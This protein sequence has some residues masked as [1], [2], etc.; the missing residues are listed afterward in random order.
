MAIGESDPHVATLITPPPEPGEAATLPTLDGKPGFGGTVPSAGTVVRYFGDYE[1]LQEIARGGMGVVFKARQVKLNRVVALKMILSGDLAGEEEVQRFK[2]EA[3]AAANLD[4]P[5]IVPIY[6]IGEHNGQH[7]FSMAFV[8]GQSLA[9]KVKDGPLTPRE[10]AQIVKRVTDSVAYAHMKGVIHRD[11]KPANVLL[12]GDGQ[13]K[14]TD[15][16]LAKQLQSDRDLTRTGAV[17]GTPSYMPPEQAAGWTDQ[18][19]P[20]SDVYS[21]GAILYCLLIGRPPFQSANPIDVLLQVREREP[22]APR[23]LDSHIDRD[24]ETICLKSPFQKS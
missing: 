6:E 14:V 7:Y 5:G 17:M 19:G 8:E 1:L 4:H 18:V 11:L 20:R 21:L 12:D 13:P 10:A 3:E 22:V 16:G 15:F 2:T 9:S 23:Q 24:L